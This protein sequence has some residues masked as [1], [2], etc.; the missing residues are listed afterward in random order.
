MRIFVAALLLISVASDHAQAKETKSD[1]KETYFTATS[2]AEGTGLPLIFRVM[3]PAK[4]VKKSDYAQMVVG[5]WKYDPKV[6]NGMPDQKTNEE[7][8]KFEDMLAST[9]PDGMGYLA[10]VV[11]GNGEKQWYWYAK[12]MAAWKKQFKAIF[13]D[14]PAFPVTFNFGHEPNWET[15]KKITSSVKK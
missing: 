15:Q 7:Q 5:T 3:E 4:S 6:R 13:L 9:T 10:L 8:I 12:D 11:T 14:K 2:K 1:S